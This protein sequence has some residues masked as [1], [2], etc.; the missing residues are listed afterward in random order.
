MTKCY[1]KSSYCIESFL[2]EL[3]Q[4]QP[5]ERI[6]QGGEKDRVIKRGRKYKIK[7][8]GTSRPKNPSQEADVSVDGEVKEKPTSTDSLIDETNLLDYL[9][10]PLKQDLEF[11]CIIRTLVDQ[12]N[13]NI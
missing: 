12:R 6:L 9:V 11:G 1:Y 13:G 2:K 10:S 7:K 3:T 5:D 8:S 4:Q